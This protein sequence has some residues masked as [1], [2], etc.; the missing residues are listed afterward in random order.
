MRFLIDHDVDV[1]VCAMLT[2]LGHDCWPSSRVIGALKADDDVAVAA[3]DRDAVCVSHD[4][5]F[6]RRQRRNTV[7]R[8]VYL[9]C[10]KTRAVEVMEQSLPLIL[11]ALQRQY[12]VIRVHIDGYEV[13]GPGWWG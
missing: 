9:D 6:Y 4:G 1:A 10:R 11:P 2:R 3:D 8:H 13:Q 5:A 7:G 12:V